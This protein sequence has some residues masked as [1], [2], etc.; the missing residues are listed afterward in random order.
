MEKN[1]GF[2]ILSSNIQS[3]NAKI[4]ELKIFIEELRE[5]GLEFQVICVQET[6]LK[7]EDD[8]S[9]FEIEGYK[10]IPQGSSCSTK[11]G[12]MVYLLDKYEYEYKSK[13]TGYESWEGQIIYIRKGNTLNKGINLINIY[14]PPNNL[15]DKC[16]EF[17]KEISPEIKKLESNKNEAIIAGDFNLDL[18]KLN[19]KNVINDYFDMLTSN[20]FYPKITLPT[21]L[22]NNHGTLIDNFFCKLTEHTLDTF[23]G[24]L[25]R[26]FSDH[27]PYFT[28]LN[29][30]QI[31]KTCT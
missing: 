16:N 10:M 8:T 26:K 28:I 5:K 4:N 31:K 20:S 25:I 22:T 7:D 6:W 15:V 13:L 30:L 12:L 17:I 21:R 9:A 2:S 18:L 24:I 23:S 11:G 29:S 19:E 14:R 1:K 27:Q 3:I